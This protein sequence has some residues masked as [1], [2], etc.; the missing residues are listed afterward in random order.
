[1]N[2]EVQESNAA[3]VNRCVVTVIDKKSNHHLHKLRHGSGLS[4]LVAQ[5]SVIEFDCLKADCGICI[6]RVLEGEQSLS[7]V[8][9]A[10]RDFL[11]AMKADPDERLAC[12]CR[13]RGDVT[14]WV[15]Y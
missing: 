10:E 13:V 12:Q 5:K 8:E 2:Q 7:A 14:L 1:M 6:V 9:I 11:T 15:E 3:A 4:A